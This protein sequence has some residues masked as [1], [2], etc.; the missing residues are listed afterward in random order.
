MYTYAHGFYVVD[1][2]L[3]YTILLDYTIVPGFSFYQLI[4]LPLPRNLLL[5]EDSARVFVCVSV[6]TDTLFVLPSRPYPFLQHS[7][8]N[9]RLSLSL[10]LCL[11]LPLCLLRRVGVFE[12][13]L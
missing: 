5:R 2:T 12:L 1:W 13:A 4:P 9:L 10:Q 8:P 3:Y 7:L 6:P 11:Y